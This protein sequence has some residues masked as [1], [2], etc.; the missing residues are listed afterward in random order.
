M[1]RSGVVQRHH[2][3][4]MHVEHVDVIVVNNAHL[5]NAQGG[6]NRGAGR[7]VAWCCVEQCLAV[8]GGVGRIRVGGS[9][10]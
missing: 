7:G 1:G 2:L 5:R 3:R 4:R 8:W 10:G 6:G 9:A